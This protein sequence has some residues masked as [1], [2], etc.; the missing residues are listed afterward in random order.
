M[1]SKPLHHLATLVVLLVLTAATAGFSSGHPAWLGSAVLAI[2][3]AKMMLVAF[4]F[5]NLRHA[6]PF[7][8]SAV[9]LVIAIFV[10]ALGLLAF[11]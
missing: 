9:V 3:F 5:M 11:R 4:R 6:H 7:W 2:A 8:K 10:S 1:T